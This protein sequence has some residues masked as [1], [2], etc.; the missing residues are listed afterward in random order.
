VTDPIALQQ[1]YQT[2]VAPSYQYSRAGFDP[3]GNFGLIESSQDQ[4]LARNMQRSMQSPAMQTIIA[5]PERQ[6]A[7]GQLQSAYQA[8]TAGSGKGAAQSPTKSSG[9][10]AMSQQQQTARNMFSGFN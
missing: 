9:K 6:A 10:G 8:P 7:Y 2:N 5:D 1:Y 4:V 3:S